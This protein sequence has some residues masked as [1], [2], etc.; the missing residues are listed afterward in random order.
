[1][2]SAFIPLDIDF[3]QKQIYDDLMSMDVF[4]K[5]LLATVIYTDGRSKYDKDGHF[6]TI[7]LHTFRV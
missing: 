2:Q 5:S 4:D 3:D 1:M 6:E 7:I